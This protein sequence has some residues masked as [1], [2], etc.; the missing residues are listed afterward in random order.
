MS[1]IDILIDPLEKSLTKKLP[2]EG[3][4]GP[5]LERAHESIKGCLRVIMTIQSTSDL[6]YNKKWEAFYQRYLTSESFSEII[7]ILKSEKLSEK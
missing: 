2:K 7:S 5:E 6:S 1:H 4:Q 3:T